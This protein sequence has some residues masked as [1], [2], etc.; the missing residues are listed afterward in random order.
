MKK[1]NFINSVISVLGVSCIFASCSFFESKEE[2]YKDDPNRGLVMRY[3]FDNETAEDSSPKKCDGVL[4]NNPNFISDTPNG[5]GKALFINGIKEQSVNI[6]YNP[7]ADS[8][9]Y[10]MCFWL[11]DFTTGNIIASFNSY[12]NKSALN[13]VALV[14]NRNFQFNT[15]HQDYKDDGVSILSGY[16]YTSIQQGAWHHI[17]F[18]VSKNETEKALSLYVDGVLTDKQ[19]WKYSES[20][21]I[22]L[23]IGNNSKGNVS[24]KLD[25]F[26]LYNRS[27]TQKE[28]KMIYKS[29]KK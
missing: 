25:N 5:I 16:D 2:G 23:Q 3:T 21:A 20:T 10:S 11:K 19:G 24:F 12:G 15:R 4:I 13:L 22:R 7:T 1:I 28:V 26:R 14:D 8:T 17:A 6:P 29:E 27:L 18:V 9:C